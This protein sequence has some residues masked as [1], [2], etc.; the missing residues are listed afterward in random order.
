MLDQSIPESRAQVE[1]LIDVKARRPLHKSVNGRESYEA[2]STPAHLHGRRATDFAEPLN[3]GRATLET[4]K[5]RLGCSRHPE[6]G[7]KSI[8]GHAHV[9]GV[10]EVGLVGSGQRLQV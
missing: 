5:N 3:G 1:Q 6:S 10:H 4:A 9:F 8:E 2:R 7:Q